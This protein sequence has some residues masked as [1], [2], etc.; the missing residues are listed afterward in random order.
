MPYVPLFIS[1]SY[2]LLVHMFTLLQRLRNAIWRTKKETVQDYLLNLSLTFP[3][4]INHRKKIPWK[5]AEHESSLTLTMKGINRG[6][7]L[8]CILY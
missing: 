1:L 3:G 7:D 2:L 8:E 4:F 5:T 6:E